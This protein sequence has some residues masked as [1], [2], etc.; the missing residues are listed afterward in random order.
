M[1]ILFDNVIKYIEEDGEIDFMILVID[2]NLY[3]FVFDNGV[4]IFVEDKKKIFDC[5]YWV[6]KVRIC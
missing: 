5:F 4:G 1:I 6:D 3:L 2:C